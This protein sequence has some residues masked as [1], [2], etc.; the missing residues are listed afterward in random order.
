MVV[1]YIFHIRIIFSFNFFWKNVSQLFIKSFLSCDF[2]KFVRNYICLSIN[3]SALS[4]P[5][6]FHWK[7]LLLDYPLLFGKIELTPYDLADVGFYHTKFMKAISNILSRNTTSQK[8]ELRRKAKAQAL[9]P[10]ESRVI[11]KKK[12]PK[13]SQVN[14]LA[15]NEGI[16][17]PISEKISVSQKA[18]A[19]Y[20]TQ[21]P[22]DARQ[23]LGQGITQAYL[24]RL[25]RYALENGLISPE[26]YRKMEVSFKTNKI[27]IFNSLES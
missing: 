6:K 9:F 24:S 16:A 7:S 20:L 22:E 8:T 5:T 4:L 1:F 25:N 27:Q 10:A 26:M 14:S 23:K 21:L 18:E 17:P 12:A 19:E 13:V 15:P 2:I 11:M 3:T